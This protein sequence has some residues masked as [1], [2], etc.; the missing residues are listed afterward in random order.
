MVKRWN[1]TLE[2]R[3]PLKAKKG[4]ERRIT[5]KVRKRRGWNSSLKPVNERRQAELD[6]FYAL[7]KILR[8]KT[9][10]RSELNGSRGDYRT[11]F[12][13]E[14]HH[15]RGRRGKRVYDP[16]NIIYLTRAQHDTIKL[17]HSEEELEAIVKPIR[18][19]Q[20]F[21]PKGEDNAKIS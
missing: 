14:P 20:G 12:G 19:K 10:G 15:I 16:F 9:K 4:L 3:K 17:M 11:G 2:Q 8:P 7:D 13:V 5:L 6:K 21:K 1:S 18:I